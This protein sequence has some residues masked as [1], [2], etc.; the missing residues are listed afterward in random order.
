MRLLAIADIDDFHWPYGRGQADVLVSCGDVCDPVILEAAAAYG[1]ALILAV[2]GNHDSPAAFAE[3]IVDLHLRVREHGGLRFGGLQGAWRYKPRGHFLYD[4][5]DT[6]R[7][8]EQL[9]AVDILLAH[10]APLGVHEID[11]DVHQGFRGL[12]EYVRRHSPQLL[13]HGHQHVS[14]ETLVDRTRVVG[15]YGHAFIETYLAQHPHEMA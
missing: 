11:D 10:N 6:T 12:A 8:L 4:Q 3:P 15:V 2:K 1:C 9:G 13:V 14:R 7:L 5:V